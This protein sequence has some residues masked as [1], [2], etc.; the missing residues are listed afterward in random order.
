MEL[1]TAITEKVT[2]LENV[3]GGDNLTGIKTATED[4]SKELSKV[5]EAVQKA[6]GTTPPPEPP[7]GTQ[8]APTD[9]PE[10]K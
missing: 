7:P 10:Q 8:S 4:L 1:A 2:A 3:K 9:E 6:S 5:Y